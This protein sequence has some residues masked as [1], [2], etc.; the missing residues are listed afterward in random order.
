MTS[1]EGY[2]VVAQNNGKKSVYTLKLFQFL[3]IRPNVFWAVFV[4]VG[5]KHYTI[6]Y[7]V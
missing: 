4:A 7:F 1:L 5:A 6:L 3:S 2:V